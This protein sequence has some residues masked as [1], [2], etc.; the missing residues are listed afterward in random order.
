MSKTQFI[1]PKSQ[2]GQAIVL[3]A[4]MIFV[5]F[6]SI[7]LA[8]DGG[9]A[10]YY[11]AAAER[12]AAS[13]ALA[14]VIFMPN[15]LNPIDSIP[16]GAGNDATD[17]AIAAA[18][19]NGFTVGV[20]NITVTVSTYTDPVSGLIQPQSL[21]VTV[22]RDVPT[23]FMQLFGISKVTVSR[24]AVAQY[25][26]P[27][28]LGEPCVFP[29]GD[30]HTGASVSQLGSG[31]YYFLRTE[32]WATDRGQGDAYT[33]SQNSAACAP[34]TISTPQCP[35]TD[36]HA[37]SAN[38][39]SDVVDPSLPG[40]GGYNYILEVP[41]GQTAQ[42][43][44]YNAAF[45]P[46]SNNPPGKGPNYCENWKTGFAQHAC[47]SGGNYYLHEDDCCAFN[48]SDK[49]TYS[50]MQYTIFN[51]PSAFVRSTDTILSQMIVRPVDASFWQSNAAAGTDTGQPAPYYIDVNTSKKITQTFAATGA[52]TVMSAYHSWVDVGG[53]VPSTQCFPTVI[54]TSGYEA[55]SSL[56]K[57]T[58]GRGP[59]G[60]LGPGTYRLRIDTLNYDGSI[61]PGNSY[62]HKGLAVR[63]QNGTG[64][65]PCGSAASPCTLS[66]LDD[67]SIY[68]PITTA[69]GGSF[70][71]P[72]FAVP[73]IYAGLTIS[74][75]VFDA[76]DAGGS[77]GGI[78]IGFVD[79]TSCATF[80][81]PAGAPAATVTDLGGQRLAPYVAP[82][83]QAP[84]GGG[85]TYA[86]PNPVEQIVNNG[87]GNVWGDNRWYRFT[88][89]IPSTYAPG[90]ITACDPTGQ[91]YWSLQYRT[92]NA[93]TATDTITVTVNL[94][95]NPAHIL[96]S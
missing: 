71:V 30:C 3:I 21:Q 32:G 95:G 1:S 68:T 5:L 70:R 22:T 73:A 83:P 55:E 77:T 79:P 25:L 54:C 69:A 60:A 18:K 41:A 91:G 35:S 49:T 62:A 12:A 13:A 48:F 4:L 31:G 16:A 88:I 37:I 87:A 19:R 8:V 76:G 72:I 56:I 96:K 36:V 11:N 59:I 6:G 38:A 67:L 29:P 74:V 51:A 66:A 9:I 92:T 39:G 45:A 78:Y 43:Q 42:I 50:A 20:N 82:F 65:G 14:G 85:G 2:A 63:V 90:A 75:D 40:P 53:Y 28:K 17:R 27:L 34:Q 44:V 64:T 94:R 33:P 47:S 86:F 93:V 89:P 80:V 7:G 46:D 84:L 58:A 15:Q 81:E 10:Y 61:P 23:F 57:Y 26:K 52:P 24:T